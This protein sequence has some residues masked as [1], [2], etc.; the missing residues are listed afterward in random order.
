MADAEHEEDQQ[1]EIESLQAIFDEDFKIINDT[2]P[3]EYDITLVPNPGG[4]EEENKVAIIANF[5]LPANYPETLPTISIRKK[6]GLPEK[7]LSTLRSMADD[8]ASE[9]IGCVSIWDVCSV[10]QDFVQ[11]NNV[12]EKTMYEQ[13]LYRQEQE[14]IDGEDEED[15]GEEIED[16]IS[17][18]FPDYTNP[19]DIPSDALVTLDSFADWRS[20][21][22]D[23]KEKLKP[24]LTEEQKKKKVNWERNVAEQSGRRPTG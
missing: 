14:D 9:S 2:V 1:E 23:E 19:F 5:K 22:D 8:A 18:K 13:M 11:D 12:A 20:Q 10:L 7:H 24:K 16:E 3:R 21:W 17:R 4:D 6:Y 15:E